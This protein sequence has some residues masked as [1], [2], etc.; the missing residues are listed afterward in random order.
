MGFLPV[1]PVSW[2][3]VV[4][5]MLG[6]VA[7]YV[8]A[9]VFYRLYISPLAQFPGPRLAASTYWLEFYYDLIKGGRFQSQIAKMHEQYGENLTATACEIHH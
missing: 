2:S 4:L 3:S 7:T 9:G 8:V 1:V 5:L 6:A